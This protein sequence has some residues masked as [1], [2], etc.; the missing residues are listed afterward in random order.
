MAD[1]VV[2]RI[3]AR[4]TAPE[5]ENKIHDDTVAR[6]FGF[7]GGLVP[8]VTVYAYLVRLPAERFGLD[9]VERGTMQARFAAP[10][11]DG[12]VI[13]VHA[14]DA[15]P[16]ALELEVRGA[17]GSVRATGTAALPE[18]PPAPS[19]VPEVRDWPVAALPAPDAR[20][21]ASEAAFG[22]GAVF[23]ELRA[24]FHAARAGEFLALIDDPLPLWRAAAVAHPGWLM[25]FAN[26]V[27]TENVRL[28]PWIHVES[29]ATHFGLVRDGDDVAIRARPARVWEHKGHRLVT[30]DEVFVVGDR[31]VMRV[32]H[33]AIYE[34]RMVHA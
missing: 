18:A 6:R 25:L 10:V 13:E 11:Y 23:G 8:G 19:S 30:L 21:P 26:W 4:N 17:D 33:T 7:A 15:G 16:G 22:A 28:G 5:S 27:L 14:R 2:Q 9:W 34:P 12:E 1:A 32:E 20:V 29:A 31:P 24:G 3:R